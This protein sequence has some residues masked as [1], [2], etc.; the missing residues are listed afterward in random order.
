MHDDKNNKAKQEKTDHSRYK[1]AEGKMEFRL[2]HQ[3]G[4]RLTPRGVRESAV[5][6][7]TKF[8]PKG[9]LL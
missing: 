6:H 2:F 3:Q 4:N 7:R 5:A 1:Q 8:G 9:L